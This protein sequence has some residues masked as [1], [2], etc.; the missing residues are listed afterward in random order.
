MSSTQRSL[1]RHP[2]FAKL[3]LGQT[4]SLFGSAVTMLALPS[5]AILTLGAKTYQVGLLE[6]AQFLAFPILGLPAG[7]WVDRLSR[8]SVMIVA[9]LGRAGLLAWIPLAWA[10]HA[11]RLWQLYVVALAIGVLTVFFDVA[12]QSYLPSLVQR[13]ALLE[14]NAKLEISRSASEVAGHGL[15]GVLVQALGAPLAILA[16]ALSFLASVC[17]L[18]LI[19]KRGSAVQPRL[20]SQTF[21]SDLREGAQVVFGSPILR[22]IAASTATSNFGSSLL[23]AVF[24]IFA[25]RELHLAPALVGVILAFGNAGVLGAFFSSRI[26]RRVGLGKTLAGATALGGLGILVTPLAAL[27]APVSLLVASQLIFSFSIPLYNV[28]QVSLRQTIVAD[29][30]QGRVNATMR[31]IA[32]GTLPLGGAIGGLLGGAIGVLPTI[33]I[34]GLIS[35][36]AALWIRCSEVYRLTSI[37]AEAVEVR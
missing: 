27:W 3:W 5:V 31:T 24:L 7:V 18:A 35:L 37:P 19:A 2:D 29:A 10:L 21:M 17:S 12:Y 11:L 33:V 22:N 34:A 26:A 13:S 4:I 25:Y 20:Q 32:W 14:G 15:G 28:N 1:W 36:S 16:D 6:S 30:L 9:D 23:S 8:K